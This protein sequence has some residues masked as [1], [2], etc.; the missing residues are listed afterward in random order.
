MKSLAVYTILLAS[1]YTSGCG[2]LLRPVTIDPAALDP[3]VLESRVEKTI[4]IND[5]QKD[6]PYYIQ[7]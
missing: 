7:F 1:L 4:N 5:T 2:V 3:T 6:L